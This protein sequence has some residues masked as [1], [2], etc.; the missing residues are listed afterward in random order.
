MK[1]PKATVRRLVDPV[2]NGRDLDLLDDLCA[3]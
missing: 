1:D 3:S 2:T